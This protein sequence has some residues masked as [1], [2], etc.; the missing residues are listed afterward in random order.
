VAVGAGLVSTVSFLVVAALEGEPLHPLVQRVAAI[1]RVVA[2]CLVVAA[3]V[4][5]WSS[6]S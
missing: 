4:L 1:D 6:R 2:G 3:G 5:A